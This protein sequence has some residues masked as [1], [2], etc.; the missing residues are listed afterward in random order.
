[1]IREKKI[2]TEDTLEGI[3][4]YT[5]F[6]VMPGTDDHIEGITGIINFNRENNYSFTFT[7]ARLFDKNGVIEKVKATL[8]INS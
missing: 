1:M 2:E 6:R 4:V 3:R 8:L 5:S 7:V